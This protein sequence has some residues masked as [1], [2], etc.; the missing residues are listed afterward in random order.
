VSAGLVISG[1][2]DKGAFAVGALQVLFERGWHFDLIAGTST[3]ALIAPLAAIGDI[4]T[5]TK[6]YTSVRRKDILRYNWRRLFRDAI[7]D[8]KPLEKLIRKT[9]KGDRYERL[10][11]SPCDVLLCSVGFQTGDILFYSQRDKVEGAIPW[12]NFDE[13]VAATLASSNQPMLMPPI[14]LNGQQCFDGGVKEVAPVGVVLK[15]GLDRVVAIANSPEKSFHGEV[16]AEMIKIGPRAID[17][18]TEETLNND[19]KHPDLL[20]IRPHELLPSNG[21]T[22]DPAVMKQMLEIGRKV[23]EEMLS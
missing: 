17:L 12:N 7:F 18:M 16:Y 14:T 2:G 15:Q 6:I 22:F 13:Y 1:G 4:E 11:A 8:T 9:M 3:G 19:L 20:V 10:M 5:A 21:L 23:A